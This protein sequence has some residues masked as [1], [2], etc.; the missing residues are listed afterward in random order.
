MNKTRYPRPPMS[1]IEPLL[2]G[3]GVAL[4]IGDSDAASSPALLEEH[5]ITTVINCAVNLD[6]DL[7]ATG[8]AEPG[9]LAHGAGQFRYYKI[10]MIDGPG[11]PHEQMLAAYFI[12]R[13]AL[14]QVMP[15]KPSYPLRDKGNVLVHCRGGR[16]RSVTLVSLFLHLEMPSRYPTLESAVA[17][18]RQARK[19]H[20][21]EWF[22]TPKPEL[23]E[24]ARVAAGQIKQLFHEAPDEQLTQVC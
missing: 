24:A 17:H 22:E 14:D 12:L 16:S 8:P 10:G 15:D 13:A 19:L 9:R 3:R 6:I 11:N 2:P 5:G 4:Y 20:P 21:N 1:L 23:F 18:V 7:V